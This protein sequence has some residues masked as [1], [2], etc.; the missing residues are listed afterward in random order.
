MTLSPHW[1]YIA[2]LSVLLACAYAGLIRL[3]NG[4]P[5]YGAFWREQA[6][7]EVAGGNCL[8]ALSAAL[9]AGAEIGLL[10]MGLNVIWGVPMIFATLTSQAMARAEE[11]EKRWA[12]D[13]R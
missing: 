5:R 2:I 6:W 11:T 3:L 4:H 1:H 10:F 7:V 12:N 13:G 8:I 9:I